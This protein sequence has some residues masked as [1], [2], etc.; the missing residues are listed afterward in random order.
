MSGLMDKAG[1]KAH[2]RTIT[3][4]TYP[5]DQNRVIVEGRLVDRRLKENYLLTGEKRPAGDIHHMVVRLLIDTAGIVIEDVEVEMVTVPRDECTQVRNS[6]DVIKGER[7]A[8]G[9][10]NRM[11]SIVGGT[12]SCTHL[13]ALLLA[14]GPA[15]LQGIFSA[16]AQKPVDLSA[17]ISDQ[18]RVKFFMKTMLNSCYVWREDGPELKRLLHLVEAARKGAKK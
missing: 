3:I 1:D 14:M 4:A 16:R 5:A 6:L 9:F 2:E 7:I 17:M 15:A 12:K 18:A 11:K 8:Q 13:V 10:T